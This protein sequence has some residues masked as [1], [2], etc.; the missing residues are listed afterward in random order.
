M[1]RTPS[2][3]VHPTM[4]VPIDKTMKALI[5]NIQKFSTEDG[6]G[7]RTTVFLKGCPLR[8]QWCHNPELIEYHQQLIRLPNRCVGCGYC[9]DH[10]PQKA[11]YRG[12]D[13]KVAIDREKCDLC[14]ACTKFCYAQSL[15][16]VAREMTP[17]E[18]LYEVAQDKEFYENTGGGMTVSGGEMLSHAPFVAALVDLAAKEGICVCLDTSGFG[19]GET[20]LALARREN[21]SHIL[22]DMKSIDDTV[23]QQY[24]GQSNRLIL[25]N[26]R[27]LASDDAVRGKLQ[28]RMPLIAGVNDTPA[29]IQ[30]TAEL[31]R[32]LGLKGVT[33]LP[34]HDLGV[35]KMRN[36][37]GSSVVFSPPSEE[38]IEE[39]KALFEKEGGMTVEILGKA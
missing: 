10:C 20:L 5:G 22:Y 12:E 11:I 23:H 9:L 29:I 32:E 38:R 30:A 39:I 24:T 26:L 33:L 16:T 36:I 6:P 25:E 37:G 2:F 17:E 27:L 34:Y 8:C 31:Y 13:G 35:S 4:P 19:D 21:V 7:I 18:I 14:L 1:H 15:Q 3:T 28:M